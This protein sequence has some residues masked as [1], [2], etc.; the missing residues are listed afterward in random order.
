MSVYSATELEELSLSLGQIEDWLRQDCSARHADD[1]A[2]VVHKAWQVIDDLA[3][4]APR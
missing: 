4:E 2:D 1:M 3:D